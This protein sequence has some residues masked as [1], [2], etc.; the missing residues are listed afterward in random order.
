M[1]P[2][3]V[4]QPPSS[5]AAAAAPERAAQVGTKNDKKLPLVD[6]AEQ[7]ELLRRLAHDEES[8]DSSA[9]AKVGTNKRKLG[10]DVTHDA[11]LL[12][13]EPRERRAAIQITHMY[14]TRSSMP[15]PVKEV[16]RQLWQHNVRE[17]FVQGSRHVVFIV[18]YKIEA[19]QAQV[20]D[21]QV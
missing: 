21:T 10:D 7:R 5:A 15:T 18:N 19:R 11:K 9:A 1:P 4:G 20:G 13:G 14:E 16:F 12:R 17:G 3:D 2:N 8:G 6:C